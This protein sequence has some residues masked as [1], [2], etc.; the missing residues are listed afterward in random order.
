M[1]RFSIG[2]LLDSFRLSPSE[3]M[4]RAAALGAEGIQVYA[5]RGELAPENMDTQKRRDFRTLAQDCGLTI[6]ALCGDLGRDFGCREQNAEL[7]ERSKRILDLAQDLGTNVVTTHIGLI[8]LDETCERYRIMQEACGELARYADSMDA[9]FA[10]ETGPDISLTLRQFLDSLHS[11]GVAVNFDP[12]NIAMVTG[13]DLVTAVR[14]LAPYIVHTHAKDG[15]MLH[16]R[17]PAFVYGG[18]HPS[19]GGDEIAFREVPLGEGSVRWPEYLGALESIGYH[20]FLTIER[21]VGENPEADIGKAVSF[22][23][24]LV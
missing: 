3:A 11:T 15:V 19:G 21:E 16:Y 12:A 8:P 1:K 13:E 14:T 9:H 22:L 5:T 6:S 7:I 18:E 10:I 24:K 4:R 17:G 2:V 23:Q 20:G